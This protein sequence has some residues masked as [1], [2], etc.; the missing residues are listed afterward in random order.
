[1]A[2]PQRRRIH[3]LSGNDVTVVVVLLLSVNSIFFLTL[4]I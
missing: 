4:L 2:L 1:M 3:W